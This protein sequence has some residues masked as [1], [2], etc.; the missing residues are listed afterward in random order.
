MAK[1]CFEKSKK[2]LE[3]VQ[4]EDSFGALAHLVER[5]NGIVEVNGSSPLRSILSET[6]FFRIKR[7]DHVFF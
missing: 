6:A 7:G 5:N 3:K 4:S 2:I 1:N